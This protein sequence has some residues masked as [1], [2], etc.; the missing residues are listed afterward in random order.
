MPK[1]GVLNNCQTPA[2]VVP[3]ATLIIP[4]TNGTISSTTI[5]PTDCLSQFV[6]YRVV[7]QDSFQRVIS[8]NYW[9]VP[10][11]LG[12]AISSASGSSYIYPGGLANFSQGI[13]AV[14]VPQT[15]AGFQFVT[16]TQNSN[17]TFTVTLNWPKAF[18]DASY[19]TV[20]S[21]LNNN[22]TPPSLYVSAI[23]QQTT[24]SVS[25]TLTITG[26]G[27][28]FGKVICFAREPV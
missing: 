17:A 27:S 25:V 3:I 6:P 26:G 16:S 20:C 22:G 10:Q 23:G 14:V 4:V 12:A 13:S 21:Y 19:I 7:L 2:V 15:I 5:I 11:T 28:S 8:T 9:Y 1:S 18:A 24:S